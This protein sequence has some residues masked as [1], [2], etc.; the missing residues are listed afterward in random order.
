MLLHEW[1]LFLTHQDDVACGGWKTGALVY[2][3]HVV[4]V[5]DETAMA[6]QDALRGL[7]CGLGNRRQAL[8]ADF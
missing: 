1:E 3:R 2:A 8:S 6:L 7:A 4:P 5:R